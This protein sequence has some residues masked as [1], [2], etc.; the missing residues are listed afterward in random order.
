MGSKT[1]DLSHTMQ[2]Y[3]PAP[4]EIPGPPVVLGWK[5]KKVELFRYAC[6]LRELC[7][8]ASSLEQSKTNMELKAYWTVRWTKIQ[9]TLSE[10]W[11]QGA[12]ATLFG[13]HKSLW[14]A[15][16][17]D[18]DTISDGAKR[19]TKLLNNKGRLYEQSAKAVPTQDL[20]GKDGTD[21]LKGEV[22]ID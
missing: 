1:K 16:F 4:Q 10:H 11:V 14:N 7:L 22:Y 18:W 3:W 6:H 5:T 9:R 8:C 19:W 2:C 12:L 20:L 15:K 13:G 21:G 17:D